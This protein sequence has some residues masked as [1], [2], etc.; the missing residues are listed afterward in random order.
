MLEG[1]G[2]A[3][4]LSGRTGSVCARAGTQLL[5]TMNL[6]GAGAIRRRV[7]FVGRRRSVMLARIPALRH[8]GGM[9]AKVAIDEKIVDADGDADPSHAAWK[10]AKI[11]RALQQ[12][13]DRAAMIPAE[14]VLRDFGF[15]P[16]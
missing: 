5:P 15:E 16:V 6:P 12:L 9:N 2:A 4:G 11:E 14:Q 8:K 10:K 7:F 1:C 13:Q 3:G